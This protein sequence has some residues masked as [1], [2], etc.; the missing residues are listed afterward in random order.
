MKKQ[1]KR[2]TLR[3]RVKR[4]DDVVFTSGKEFNRYDSDGNRAPYRGKVIAVDPRNRKV[5]VEG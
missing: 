1:A 4:G 2:G 5:K 3:L